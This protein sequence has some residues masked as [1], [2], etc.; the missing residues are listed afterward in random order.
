M[1][2]SPLSL[3]SS[4]YVDAK[5]D[6]SAVTN[7][8]GLF[9]Y[10]D[11]MLLTDLP[12]VVNESLPKW[13]GNGWR[14]SDHLGALVALNLTGGDCVDDLQK[15]E[16][17]PG[18]SLYM[19]QIARATGIEKR[20]FSRGG[21]RDTPSLTSLREWL[22][23]FH[24]DEGD[25]KR[26]YGQAFVPEA[27]KA[28]TGLGGVN[29]EFVTR[30]FRLYQR[31]GRAPVTQ[32]TLEPDATF[33]ETQ[34]RDALR[35]YKKFE[36]YSGL[37]VRWEEMG[38]AIWDEFRDGNV[39]P[40]YRNLEA[41]TESITYLNKELG[42][43]DVWVRSDEAAHQESILKALSGW[44]IDGKPSPIK[45]AIGY[46]KT[47]EFREEIQKLRGNEWEK[48][49][50]AKGRLVHE[51]AESSAIGCGPQAEVPFVSNTEA[52][53]KGEPYR[54]VVIRRQAKQGILPGLG[55]PIRRGIRRDDGDTGTGLSRA[56]DHIK[57]R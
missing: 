26:G 6:P 5:V 22:E 8:G 20:R 2:K 47:R 36:A 28:L 29:R 57:H 56:C 16:G 24:N 40:G 10:L 52:M 54:H 14:H 50:D 18:I 3:Y 19:G 32:A 41:L 34:K 43:T 15:I 45:F 30:G 7:Y 13:R 17:D 23:Q 4:Y 11:L 1:S 48:V 35:C 42:I 46:V 21:D 53:I 55:A 9:P 44:K 31:S 37:T 38:F 39:P 51:V 25:A 49:Y 27:N 12:K 33:M